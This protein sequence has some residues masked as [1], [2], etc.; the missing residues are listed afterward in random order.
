MIM[1]RRLRIVVGLLVLTCAAGCVRK[2]V[3]SG[4][5]VEPTG[6]SEPFELAHVQFE[7]NATDGDVEVVFEAKAGAEG[8][9]KLT[10]KAPD[11]RAVVDVTAP[12]TSTLGTRQ[13]RFE[14]PETTD[15]ERLKAAYPEGAYTFTGV[16]VSGKRFEGSSTLSHQVPATATL[17]KPAPDEEDVNPRRLVLKWSSVLNIEAFIVY[18]EQD[19]LQVSINSRVP[20]S[21]TSFE[22]PEGFLVPGTEYTV[23]LGTVT[24]DGNASF[25]ETTFKT[26]GK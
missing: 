11:G 2:E 19:V 12:D 18:I 14:S 3:G 9:A 15:A 17:L 21:V 26:A 10:V 4:V 1:N 7:H 24:K 6:A 20:G 22:V 5:A 13:F 8:L 23:G 25:V 16:T